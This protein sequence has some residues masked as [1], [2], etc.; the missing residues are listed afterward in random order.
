MICFME[1]YDDTE[2]LENDCRLHPAFMR[3]GV[4]INGMC[5]GENSSDRFKGSSVLPGNCM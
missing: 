3:D 2:F 1:Q 5:V 4:R